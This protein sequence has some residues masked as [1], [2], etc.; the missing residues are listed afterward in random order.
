MPPGSH[1]VVPLLALL[2]LAGLM[3]GAAA[4][5]YEGPGQKGVVPVGEGGRT[6]PHLEGIADDHLFAALQGIPGDACRIVL[7]QNGTYAGTGVTWEL[8]SDTAYVWAEAGDREAPYRLHALWTTDLNGNC[9]VERT[10]TQTYWHDP[11]GRPYV[12]LRLLDD[13]QYLPGPAGSNITVRFTVH[14]NG[15]IA[16]NVTAQM[17]VVKDTFRVTSDG[18]VV[19]VPVQPLQEVSFAFI[20]EVPRDTRPVPHTVQVNLV[21]DSGWRQAATAILKIGRAEG[22]DPVATEKVDPSSAKPL[23]PPTVDAG[24]APMP[25]AMTLLAVAL[26]LAMRRR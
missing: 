10:E 17:A 7:D 26:A 24:E 9:T 20:V 11:R 12:E 19:D 13:K 5:P 25:L 4:A 16:D 6:I 2:L 15:T 8:G 3:P 22:P 1:A 18:P 21:G 23:P 14:N